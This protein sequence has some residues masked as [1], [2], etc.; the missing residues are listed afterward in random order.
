MSVLSLE[1]AEQ[2]FHEPLMAEVEPE[3]H[4]VRVGGEREAQA[5]L[6]GKIVKT[7]LDSTDVRL[8]DASGV[9]H[10]TLGL[11][12]LLHQVGDKLTPLA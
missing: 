11:E 4:G 5:R 8:M 2:V 7:I 10:R 1:I 9:S 3:I 6:D 12:V